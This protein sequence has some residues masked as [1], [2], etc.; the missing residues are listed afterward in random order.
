MIDYTKLF[1]LIEIRGMK[2]TDL[3]EVISSP[4]L[5][6]LGKNESVTMETIDK[7]CIF[8]GVQPSD[9]VEIYEIKE[10]ENR[11]IKAKIKFPDVNRFGE[12]QIIAPI[13]KELDK[14]IVDKNGQKVLDVE[15]LYKDIRKLEINE[16]INT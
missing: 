14:Y 4:T 12:N 15:K 10:I 5:A 7:L 2:K 13:V 8:L 3:L 16:G 1:D 11:K 9:I 6:K